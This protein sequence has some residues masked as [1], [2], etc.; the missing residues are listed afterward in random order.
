LFFFIDKSTVKI[1]GT[2]LLQNKNNQFINLF[3]WYVFV[4][5]EDEVFIGID[6]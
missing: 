3:L 1:N 5:I 4:K 2:V 6:R